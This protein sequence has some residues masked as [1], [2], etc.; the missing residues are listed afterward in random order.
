[1]QV[2]ISEHLHNHS[3]LGLTT[4]LGQGAR[5]CARDTSRTLRRRKGAER[6]GRR[7]PIALVRSCVA[8][9][10]YAPLDR[11]RAEGWW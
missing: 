9:H 3:G 5:V 2:T 1:M 10:E 6:S 8:V 11:T 7:Q 4:Q